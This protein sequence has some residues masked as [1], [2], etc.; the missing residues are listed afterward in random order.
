[1]GER[2]CKEKD[3]DGHDRCM[4]FHLQNPFFC[5]K[6]STVDYRFRP[7]PSGEV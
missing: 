6:M 3:G 7:P 2:A 4:K 5:G 1:M